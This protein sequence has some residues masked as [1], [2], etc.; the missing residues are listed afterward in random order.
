MASLET[1]TALY[2][3]LAGAFPNTQL[4]DSAAQAF[5][6]GTLDI[7][8]EL[9]AHAIAEWLA[10][11][12]KFPTVSELRELA[13]DETY[14]LPGEA[15][16]EV[17]RAISRYGQSGT[18]E[19]SHALIAAAVADIGWVSLCVSQVEDE[20]IIRA[21][22]ERYY[23]ARVQRATFDRTA[24]TDRLSALRPTDL[25]GEALPPAETNHD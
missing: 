10:H 22:F 7:P 12:R 14:P 3:I 19:F 9:L 8:D 20:P 4:P 18:P 21:Q 6:L 15:W 1:F 2:L 24:L 17:R 25:G 13:L 16:G 5:Y 11:G 23:R